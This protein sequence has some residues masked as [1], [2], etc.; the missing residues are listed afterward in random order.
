[1][2]RTGDRR[3]LRGAAERHLTF[4]ALPQPKELGDG[5]G[6]EHEAAIDE[7]NAALA[8]LEEGTPGGAATVQSS[9]VEA[10]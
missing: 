6:G 2:V 5:V 8:L 9:L 7:L 4:G 10:P 1:M 3:L